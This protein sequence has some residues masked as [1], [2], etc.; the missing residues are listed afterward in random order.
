MCCAAILA[1]HWQPLE[2][3]RVVSHCPDLMPHSALQKVGEDL[4]LGCCV[5][6]AVARTLH[7]Y[8]N[9]AAYLYKHMQPV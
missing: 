4:R 8:E 1:A 6:I 9:A 7:T 3:C 5:L 2:A